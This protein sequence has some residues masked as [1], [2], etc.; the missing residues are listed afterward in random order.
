MRGEDRQSAGMF[1]YVRLEERVPGDHPLRAIRV[2]VDAA[3]KELSRAFAALYARVGR[4][5]VPP[6]RLLRALLL[7]AFYTIRSERLLMEQLDYNLLF[8][9]FVGLSMDDDVWDATVFCK[10]R[11]RLLDGDIAAKFLGSVLSLPQVRK[12]LSS[13]HF[14]VDGTLI[15]AWASMKSFVPKDG[16]G[17]PPA[18]GGGRNAERDF[19]G[20]KR[21]NDTH[22]STTDP[23]A[24][25]FRKGKGKEAKLC[26]MGHLMTENR[27][28]LIVDAKLTEANG[29][30]E[31]S[32]ALDMLDDNAGSR[33][34]VGANKNYDTADFV[35][36]LPRTRMRAPRRS[37]RYQSTLG[38]RCTHDAPSRLCHQH[39]QTQAHRRALRLDEDRR[40]DAQDPSS[41]ATSGRMVLRPHGRCLQPHS[42]PEASG[43]SSMNY[44]SGVSKMRQEKQTKI[45]AL[46]T[47]TRARPELPDHQASESS[48][49]KPLFPQP[50]RQ[51]EVRFCRMRAAAPQNGDLPSSPLRRMGSCCAVGERALA[52]RSLLS[53]SRFSIRET[54]GLLA[55]RGQSI[56]C[57]VYG[58]HHEYKVQDRGCPYRR[59][60]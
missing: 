17:P 7:Q 18:A 44:C 29:T 32:A 59:G 21:S 25:L 28:G 24:R 11:D 47:D 34:T 43:R 54:V 3:L 36:R 46:G 16:S 23:D 48:T 53:V 2:L 6:E 55:S 30:A 8:R 39:D 35:G 33:S 19:H 52:G 40:R 41:R 60:R 10:N 15:E 51:I 12:L 42:H 57:L 31:C 49:E 38:H 56:P 37:E 1:S 45:G 58:E 5:S 22:A 4:P 27:H 26:H 20:E 14:S 13:E 50:A 9:W